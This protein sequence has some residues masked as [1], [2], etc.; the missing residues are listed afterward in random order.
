MSVG[1]PMTPEPVERLRSQG[2]EPIPLPLGHLACEVCGVAVPVDVFA[3]VN[4]PS[5]AKLEPP[6][7]CPD[8]RDLRQQAE[9]FAD[10]NP[11][12]KHR[13]GVEVAEPLVHLLGGLA[14][15]GAVQSL[16]L[17]APVRVDV[18]HCAVL[19]VRN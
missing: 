8:C 14:T 9:E 1:E 15:E 6:R 3:D 5:K 11:V 10:E 12:L 4:E 18:A 16:A 7:R 13:L 17:V 2:A 19:T